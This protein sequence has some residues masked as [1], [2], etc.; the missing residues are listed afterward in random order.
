MN[1]SKKKI[2]IVD[3]EPTNLALLKTILQDHYDLLFTTN[4]AKV[5]NIVK[6]EMPD[7]ILLDVMMPEHN[8]YQVCK[9][10]KANSNTSNIPI[11]FVTAVNDPK[12]EAHGFNIGAVDYISKPVSASIVLARV[13]THIKLHEKEV[14]LE[15]QVAERTKAIRLLN[16]ELHTTQQSIIERLGRAAE[17]KDNETG[18]HVIRM[19]HYSQI[20][21]IAAGLSESDAKTLLLAAPMHDIGKIGIPDH[22][23]LKPGKLDEEEWKIMRQHPRIGAGIIGYHDSE[24]LNL[25]RIVA[26]TH[27]EKWNGTGYPNGLKGEEIPLV[28]RIVAIAD[29]FDA[30]TT[31]RPYK[32]AWSVERAIKL[33]EEEKGKHF[34]PLLVTLFIDNLPKMLKIRE[35]WTEKEKTITKGNDEDNSRFLKWKSEYSVSIE[36]LDN[37]HK[38]I[39]DLLN[40][41]YDASTNE[42]DDVSM[43]DFFRRLF[44]YTL[45]HFRAEEELMDQHDYPDISAHKL[46]HHRLLQE[47]ERQYNVYHSNSSKIPPELFLML[48][49]WWISHILGFDM[50]YVPFLTED[51]EE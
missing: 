23:L 9:E 39:I 25:S 1:V 6:N 38:E 4:G 36:E 30:L 3:D 27:H 21:G 29:V 14:N 7:L 13:N 48:K 49:D 51:E 5:L 11:I 47:T 34:E 31:K 45:N 32:E 50:K 26:L 20:L 12:A 19:S 8:G 44:E 16:S 18:L 24:L 41:L 15:K 22:I 37:D 46:Q 33:L 17:Y 2:L 28:G 42:V 40:I 10:L 35:Q 43:E